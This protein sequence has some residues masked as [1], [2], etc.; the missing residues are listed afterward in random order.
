MIERIMLT[1]EHQPSKVELL[2]AAAEKPVRRVFTLDVY[3]LDEDGPVF[4][5]YPDS[6]LRNSDIP[7]RVQVA[8]GTT[9]GELL[10]YVRKLLEEIR[11][12]RGWNN[13]TFDLRRRVHPDT[14]TGDQAGQ[15]HW[16]K[17]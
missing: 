8:D 10:F 12:D 2:Q 1:D 7:I 17:A 13:L 3:G 11:D 15:D 4:E 14:D 6:E 9:R 5:G 16:S